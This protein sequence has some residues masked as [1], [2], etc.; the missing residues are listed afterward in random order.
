MLDYR[1]PFHSMAHRIPGVHG[2]LGH[3]HLALA[4]Q[5][6]DGRRRRPAGR[7]SGLDHQW[8]DQ[9]GHRSGGTS[10][11][12]FY[13][14]YLMP[15]DGNVDW[16]HL[17][18]MELTYMGN[19]V[20]NMNLCIQYLKKDGTAPILDFSAVHFSVYYQHL[21]VAMYKSCLCYTPASYPFHW[22]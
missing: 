11:I 6:G 16:K 2:L 1:Y 21:R 8:D 15:S 12:K 10:S 18:T 13:S 9:A 3:H 17:I 4:R 7:L 20:R 22:Y 19:V 14:H 5:H